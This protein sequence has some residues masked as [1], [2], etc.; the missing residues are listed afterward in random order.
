MFNVVPET[1]PCLGIIKAGKTEFYV[2]IDYGMAGVNDL[3][4]YSNTLLWL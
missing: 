1:L 2:W 3:R 4:R